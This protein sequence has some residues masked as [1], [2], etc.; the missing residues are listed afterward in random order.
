LSGWTAETQ[1]TAHKARIQQRAQELLAKRRPGDFNQAWMDL[2]SLICTPRAPRCGCCPLAKDC[3]AFRRSKAMSLPTSY[4]R[5]KAAVPRVSIAVALFLHSGKML[6]RRRPV[7]GLWSGLWEFPNAQVNGHADSKGVIKTLAE[8]EGLRLQ[9]IP[10][11]LGALKHRLTHRA[12]E[13]TVY[14]CEAE[15]KGAA[16][17]E[18][19]RQ[20]ADL[21]RFRRVSVS[22]AHRRIHALLR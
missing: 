7:G 14:A 13:F 20:W 11:R 19:P 10:R 5:A 16:A 9:E 4:A 21:R 17:T 2:G 8:E 12:I 3:L 6:L 15:P 18:W 22:T 1:T